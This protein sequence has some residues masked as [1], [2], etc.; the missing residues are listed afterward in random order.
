MNGVHDMG[1][2]EGLGSLPLEADEPVFHEPWEGR[3]VALNMAMGAWGRGNVDAFRHAIERIPG[4]QYLS[5]SYYQRW[6]VAVTTLAVRGGLISPEELRTLTIDPAG[7]KREPRLTAERVPAKLASK[8]PSLRQTD[9]PA[10]FRIGESVR[11]R[12]VNVAG[13]TRLP[14]YV[15]GHIGQ[16]EFDHGAHVLPDTNAHF[17]GEQPQRLYGVVF[18][19]HELWGGPAGDA[20]RLDLWESYLEPA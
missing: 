1:G 4:P 9:K 7:E 13:H 11:A 20:I 6:L 2:M 5:M 18:T 3:V 15:R 10:R 16:I 12:M 8:A 19:A 17:Q 14:R